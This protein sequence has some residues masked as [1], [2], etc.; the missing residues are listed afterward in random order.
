[1]NRQKLINQNYKGKFENEHILIQRN[2]RER[3]INK[4]DRQIDITKKRE[5]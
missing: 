2:H 1:M 5:I 3:Q 4:I